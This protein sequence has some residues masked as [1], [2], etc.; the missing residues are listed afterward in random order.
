[1]ISTLDGQLNDNDASDVTRH[2]AGVFS[3]LAI[4]ASASTAGW[5]CSTILPSGWLG[6]TLAA[7]LAWPLVAARSMHVGAGA[8]V[9]QMSGGVVQSRGGV[10]PGHWLG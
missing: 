4:I 5:I 7:I 9:G 8:K 6:L 2:L 10:K 3:A 1:M